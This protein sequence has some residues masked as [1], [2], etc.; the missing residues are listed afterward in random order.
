MLLLIKAVPQG[1][2][3][4]DVHEHVSTG[5]PPEDHTE[6]ATSLQR[7]AGARKRGSKPMMK[8]AVPPKHPN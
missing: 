1:L 3:A 5:G 6:A 2:S 7:E 8:T 4:E